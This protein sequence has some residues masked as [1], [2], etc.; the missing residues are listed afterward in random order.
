MCP[1]ILEMP[2][3]RSG[4]TPMAVKHQIYL[5]QSIQEKRLSMKKQAQSFLSKTALSK[6]NT[7]LKYDTLYNRKFARF[8]YHRSIVLYYII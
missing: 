3:I 4:L 2:S 7:V 1:W 5:N 8:F 6:K